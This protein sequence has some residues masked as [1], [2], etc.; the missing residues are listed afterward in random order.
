M[1]ISKE[2]NNISVFAM[3]YVRLLNSFDNQNWKEHILFYY[4]SKMLTVKRSVVC[5]VSLHED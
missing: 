1:H 2:H 5:G 4:N 3:L